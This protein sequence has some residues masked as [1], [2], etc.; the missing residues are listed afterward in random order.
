[1]A[2]VAAKNATILIGGYSLSTF[3]ANYELDYSVEPLEVTGFGDTWRNYI[4]GKF[5]GQ[6]SLNMYWDSAANSANAALQA[7]GKKC[8]TVIPETYALGGNAL[9]GYFEQANFTP[10]ANPDSALMVGNVIF[11]ASGVDGGPLPAQVLQHG[12]ITTTTTTTA[13]DD[14]SGEAAT[15]RCAGVLHVWTPTTADSYVVKIQHC[16]TIGGSYVDLVTFTLNGQ[17]RGSEKVVVASGT[18]NEYRKV[19]ATRTGTAGNTL[20]FTVSFW[21]AGM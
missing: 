16:D 13:V 11:Q 4:P 2:K 20:G 8:V 7:L 15:Q 3:A 17:A 9:T 21:H 1:M 10:Q 19:V 12:T 14:A 18:V 5:T 6:M